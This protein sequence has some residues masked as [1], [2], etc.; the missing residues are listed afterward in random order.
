MSD[1]ITVGQFNSSDKTWTVTKD[2]QTF[3]VTD[4]NNNGI[5]DSKDSIKAPS[6]A[7]LSSEDLYEAQYQA[8]AQDGVTESE[9]KKYAKFNELRE[10]RDKAQQEAYDKELEQ[11]YAAL[12]AKQQQ[13]KTSWMDK[14]SK[15]LNFGMQATTAIGMIGMTIDMFKGNSN[16]WQFGGCCNDSKLWSFTNMSNA[17]LS[18]STMSSMLLP[19]LAANSVPTLNNDI[20]GSLG[21]NLSTTNNSSSVTTAQA[22]L[23]NWLAAQ[24]KTEKQEEVEYT[25]TNKLVNTLRELSQEK[26][27]FIPDGNEAMIDE[28][29]SVGKTEYTEDDKEKIDKLTKYTYIPL[30]LIGNE[31]GKLTDKQAVNVNEVIRNYVKLATTEEGLMRYENAGDLKNAYNKLNMALKNKDVADIIK[32][33]DELNK[34]KPKLAP[35]DEEE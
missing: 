13:K 1:A 26:S 21:L 17:M 4:T 14:A 7:T 25:Q 31:A 12:Q 33:A 23:D 3:T 2:G 22:N 6:G 5:W 16:D 20:W 34:V 8:N 27:D 24:T 29:T 9:M 19:N 18:M 28:L 15:I 10:A 11:K 32:Y 35:A 30:D